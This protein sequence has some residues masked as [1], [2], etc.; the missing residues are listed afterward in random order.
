MATAAPTGAFVAAGSRVVIIVSSGAP[1]APTGYT[2]VPDVTGW[3]QGQALSDLQSVG[4]QARV[5]NDYSDTPRGKVFAQH[6]VT[7]AGVARDSETVLLVSSGKH[8]EKNV[9]TVPLP[10]VVGLRESEAVERL[11]RAGLSPQVV[12]EPS[13]NTQAGTVVAQLPNQATLATQPAGSPVWMWVL[14]AIALL[15]VLGIVWFFLFGGPKVAVPSV[16]GKSQANATKAITD[17]GLVVG[18]VTATETSD[19][20]TGSVAAQNPP[21][22][23]QVR[24]GSPVD[25]VIVGGPEMVE[26]PDVR[27]KSRAEATDELEE[28]GF[29]VKVTEAPSS[30]VDKG[31]VSDQAPRPGESLP[32]GSDVGIV[33]S[34]GVE[35]TE[36]T[37]PDVKGLTREDAEQTLRELGLSVIVAENPSNSVPQGAVISQV[38]AAGDKVAEGTTVGL[39]VSSGPPPGSET[40][41]VPELIGLSLTEAQQALSEAGLGAQPAPISGTG[42]PNN[43]VVYQSPAEGAEVAPGSTVLVLYSNGK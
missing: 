15:A 18:S 13:V 22:G 34:T 17:A 39:V 19:R 7:G 31:F 25:L 35:S 33:V 1:Q 24:E 5:I 20:P 9:A 21:A 6:P 8:P 42:K 30:V 36:V 11:E 4:L 23:T 38:P 28:A 2:T 32:K 3:E 29:T 37:I 43:E 26:V 16:T 14:A 12:R 10:D 41:V 27:K 40:V